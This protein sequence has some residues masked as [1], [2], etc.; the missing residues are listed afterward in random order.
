MEAILHPLIQKAMEQWVQKQSTSLIF[1]E[2]PLLFESHTEAFS[3]IRSGVLLR[4]K[5][6]LYPA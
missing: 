5:K 2:V 3:L 4:L 6:W 1:I